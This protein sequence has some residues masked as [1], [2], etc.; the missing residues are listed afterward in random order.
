MNVLVNLKNEQEEKVLL[1]FL[2]SLNYQYQA[3]ATNQ[4]NTSFIDQY[5]SELD[6]ADQEIEAGNFMIQEEVVNLFQSRRKNIG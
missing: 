2:N 1:A 3:D 4:L 5:S 6:L